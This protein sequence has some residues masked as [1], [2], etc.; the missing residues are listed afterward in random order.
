MDLKPASQGYDR[1]VADLL[2]NGLH[3]IRP[4]IVGG[5]LCSKDEEPCTEN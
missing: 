5:G 4:L 2:I 1:Q 3:S